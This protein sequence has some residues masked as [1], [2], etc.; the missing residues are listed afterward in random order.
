ME[1]KRR[2]NDYEE[3]GDMFKGSVEAAGPLGKKPKSLPPE[4]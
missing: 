4:E 2:K 1:E 3:G